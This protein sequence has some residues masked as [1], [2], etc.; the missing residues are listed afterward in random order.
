MLLNITDILSKIF[1]WEEFRREVRA[2]GE[3]GKGDAFELLTQYFL[4]IEPRYATKLSKVWRLPEVPLKIAEK[5]RLPPADKGIDLIAETKDGEYWAVQCKYREDQTHSL[6]WREL[7]TF[8]GLAFTVCKGISFG[9]VCTNTERFTGVLKHQDKIGFCTLDT[10]LDLDKTFFWNIR[11]LLRHR[12]EKITPLRPRPHQKKAVNEASRHFVKGRQKRGKLIMPCGTGKSL[13]AF[14]IARKLKAR[15]ILIAVPSLALIRQTLKVWLKEAIAHNQPIEWLCVCS[16]ETAG[17]IGQDD[18]SVLKQDLGVPCFTNPKEI[19]AKLKTPAHGLTVVFTTYQSGKAIADASRKTGYSFDLGIMDEAHKTVG[20][21]DKLFTH[22]LYDRNISIRRRIF[23]TAT[24]RRYIGQNDEIASM[25]DEKIYGDTFSLLSFKEALEYKPPILSDYRIITMTVSRDEV[26]DLIRKNLFVRP[27]KGPWDREVEAEMLASLVALRKAMEKYP[28]RHAVSFHS[29]IQRARVFQENSD[30]FTKAFPKYGKLEAFHVSGKTPTGTRARTLGDFENASRALITNARC[31]TEG[32]D[33]PDIDCVLFADPRKSTIDI[34]QAV[35]RALRPAKGK[36]R[37]YVVIPILHD[38]RMKSE[39]FLESEEFKEVLTTL[40][41]LASNDDRIIEFFRSV[42]KGRQA[43][44]GGIVEFDIDERIGRKIKIE[45]FVKAVELKCWSRLARL[46]WREFEDAREYVRGLHLKSRVEW[47][48]FYKGKLPE[49]GPFPADIPLTPDQ[50][51]R[52]KGWVS[53]GDWL[54]TGTI[55]PQLRHYRP[56]QKARAFVIR[57]NIKNRVEWDL[58]CKGKLLAKGKLPID[59]PAKP[60]RVYKEKGWVGLGDWLGTGAV[61]NF[62]RKYRPYTRA[63]VFVH[64]LKLK[65]QSE[66]F[67]YCKGQ[68]PEKGK[69][70]E[71]IPRDPFGSYRNK[72]WVSYG[73][74]L[75]TGRIADHLHKYRAFLKARTFVHKLNFKNQAEWSLYCKGQ[76]KDKGIKPEDIPANPNNTY[77]AKGW[78]SM[79]DWLGT[80][81]VA[82]RLRKYR[83]F[84]K[85]RAFARRLVLRS[86]D[87]WLAFCRGQMPEKGKLPDDIPTFPY[88]TYRNKGWVS[89]GDWLGSGFIAPYL[90]KYRSFQKARVFVRGLG[91]KSSAQWRKYCKGKMRTKSKLPVD[92]PS[93]PNQVYRKKGWAGM[94]DWLGTGNIA[95]SLRHY[96]SFREARTFARKLKFRNQHEWFLFCKEQMRKKG[97]LPMDISSTPYNAY[98][99]KGWTN[100]GDWLGTGTV[101]ARLRQFRPFKQARLFVR[102]LGL[103]SSAQ[104]KAYC[105]G[106]MRKK[107]KLPKDIPSNPNLPYRNKGWQDMGDWLGTGTIAPRLRIYRPYKQAHAFVQRLKLKSGYEWS[108]YC[109]GHLQGKSKKPDDIPASAYKT[110]RNNGWRGMKDWLGTEKRISSKNHKMKKY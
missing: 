49:K 66:W 106:K 62:L 38:S 6:T 1:S 91:L 7:S 29:S 84:K 3:K 58:F 10:W 33:V 32:V 77:R 54:G 45:E 31:L 56:F 46:S 42:S 57:L 11:A 85:A 27:D 43:K 2:L 37:G 88:Q 98:K 15:K 12:P 70:P 72:G 74:W 99:K 80:G 100:W 47:Q 92:I 65:S 81:T 53:M 73:D 104:W 102:K 87:Q 51:Y 83:E 14:W 13:A 48:A 16:D 17:R 59:I 50:A 21:K 30:A 35:G 97:R 23:M 86:E 20:A 67:A 79:G 41:A 5:L 90:R 25:E 76:M 94:G 55:A 34:V 71:D 61:A 69:L 26:A 110:Y 22:L 95:P 103:K 68:M 63:R 109:K 108:A 36:A 82:P 28:I 8:T 4:R 39:E 9:L 19:A 60:E 40:R 75:G 107:G 89:M 44:R 96:R 18:V 105:G 52:N 101:A 24:E 78:I 64:K 93:D